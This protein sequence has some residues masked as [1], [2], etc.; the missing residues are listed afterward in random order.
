MTK[1]SWIHR[2]SY[3]I[4]NN[5]IFMVIKHNSININILQDVPRTYVRNCTLINDQEYVCGLV[6]HRS[7]LDL[8]GLIHSVGL[9]KETNH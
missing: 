3:I 5:S 1:I 8:L 2:G 7:C 9:H 6:H 4:I